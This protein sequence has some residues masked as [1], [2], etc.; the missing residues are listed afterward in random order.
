MAF[1]HDGDG[2]GAHYMVQGDAH[3]LK[4]IHMLTLLHVLDKVGEHFRV[5]RRKE[6]KT[7]FFQFLSK[8]QVVLDDAVMDQGQVAR[9]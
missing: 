6:G 8:A 3:G 2:I 1:L 7:A 5:G 4:Q 9:L